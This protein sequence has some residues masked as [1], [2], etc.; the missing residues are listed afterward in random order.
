MFMPFD[1]TKQP[2]TRSHQHAEYQ[3]SPFVERAPHAAAP[4]AMRDHPDFREQADGAP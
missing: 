4:A 3:K 1:R 2:T